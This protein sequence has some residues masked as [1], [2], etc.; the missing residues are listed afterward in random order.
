MNTLRNELKRD[1][2]QIPN[3]LITDLTLSA[4]ALRVLLYLFTKPDEWNVYNSDI[5]NKLDINE[6]T[7]ARY[8]KELLSS[9]WLRR[10]KSISA[11]GKFTGGYIYHIGQFTT[12]DNL[13]DMEKCTDIVKTNPIVTIKENNKKKNCDVFLDFLK[14][15]CKYKTKVTKTKEFEQLFKTIK[16]YKQFA[17]DYIKHQEDKKEYSVRI[18]KFLI[19]YETVYKSETK[20]Q[21]E[22]FGEYKYD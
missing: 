2:S 16:D 12:S 10:T 19:D 21:H 13:S 22:I 1:Y 7:L 14:T 5:C 4:G 8:W 18:T 15:K 20:K 6:K 3:D 11:D 17:I 9:K